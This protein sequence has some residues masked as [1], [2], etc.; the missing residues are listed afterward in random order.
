MVY[1]NPHITGYNPLYTA[2]N[3]GFGHCPFEVGKN[4]GFLWLQSPPSSGTF[5]VATAWK[6]KTKQFEFEGKNHL[7]SLKGKDL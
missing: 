5:F 4:I 7:A 2:I 1:N 3:Q 6:E